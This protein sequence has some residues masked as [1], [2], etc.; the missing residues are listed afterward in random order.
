WSQMARQVAH[1]IKNPLTP[2]A[3]SV[4]DLKRSYELQRPDFPEILARAARTIDDEVHG[5]K[6]MLDEFSS[7]GSLPRPQVAPFE[8]RELFS[9]LATLYGREIT[10]G[11]LV[12]EPPDGGA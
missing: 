11:R 10:A 3:I 2:I 5:L 7:L 8:V 6:R 9:D 1:E 12:L 4:A